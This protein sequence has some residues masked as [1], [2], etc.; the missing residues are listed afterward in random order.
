[1]PGGAPKA[2][3][4]AFCIYPGVFMYL[5][6]A[7]IACR[8]GDTTERTLSVALGAVLAVLICVAAPATARAEGGV[9]CLDQLFFQQPSQQDGRI[10]T[11][12]NSAYLLYVQFDKNVSYAQPGADDAFVDDNL[13]K[14]RLTTADGTEVAG[15]WT[16]GAHDHGDRQLIYVHCDEWLKPLTEYHVVVDAGVTAGNGTD[17]LGK[18]VEF[19]FYT[20]DSLSNGWRIRYIVAVVA[21]V[22]AVVGGVAVQLVRVAKRKGMLR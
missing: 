5:S 19:T 9:T 6:K 14:V 17:E 3:F 22:L 1:M 12:P 21:T 4:L 20:D 10:S 7:S 11:Q 18:S 15:S 16:S 13:S 2:R 8:A